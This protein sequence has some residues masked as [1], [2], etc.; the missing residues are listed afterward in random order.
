M[1]QYTFIGYSLNLPP[2]YYSTKISPHYIYRVRLTDLEMEKEYD[3]IQNHFNSN[4]LWGRIDHI[5]G[6]QRNNDGWYIPGRVAKEQFLKVEQNRE[7]RAFI[8]NKKEVEDGN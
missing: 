6:V 3:L 1:H 4:N 2:W 8:R 7:I 5:L